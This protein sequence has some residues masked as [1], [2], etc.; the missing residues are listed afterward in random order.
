MK[1]NISYLYLVICILTGCQSSGRQNYN[2]EQSTYPSSLDSLVNKFAV[3]SSP[4]ILHTPIIQQEYTPYSVTPDD[5]YQE[6]YD[7][8]YEQG[9][10][11]GRRGL[12]HGWGY[13]DSCDYYDYFE[14]RY[15]EGYEEAYDDGYNDGSSEFEEEDEDSEEDE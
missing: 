7:N 2:Q 1:R 5:A 12:S 3:P 6:G 11:D 15:E 4:V 13:D 14:T 10:E 9:K 8:G